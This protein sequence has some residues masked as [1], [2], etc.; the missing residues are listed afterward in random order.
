MYNRR[1]ED[2]RRV[3]TSHRWE[4]AYFPVGVSTSGVLSMCHNG[5]REGFL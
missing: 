1:W 2:E 5:S 4:L 3:E